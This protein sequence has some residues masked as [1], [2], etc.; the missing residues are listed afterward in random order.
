MPLKEVN[1]VEI[2][3]ILDNNIDPTHW[4]AREFPDAFVQN[5]VGT[6]FLL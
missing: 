6:R 2:L 5:N 1:R 3:T 4:T